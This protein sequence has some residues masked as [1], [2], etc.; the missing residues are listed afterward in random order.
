MTLA[1]VEV[2]KNTKNIVVFS[3]YKMLSRDCFRILSQSLE[4]CKEVLS[5]EFTHLTCPFVP[6]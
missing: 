4:L 1:H 5:N 6:V 2:E 3:S